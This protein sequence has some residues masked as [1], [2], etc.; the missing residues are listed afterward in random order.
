MLIFYFFILIRDKQLRVFD[1][2]KGKLRRKYDES[3]QVYQ[4]RVK[5]QN[6][7]EGNFLGK[8]NLWDGYREKYTDEKIERETDRQI[9]MK[10]I[11]KK[12]E[13]QRRREN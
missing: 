1:F 10:M 7:D 4:V 3:V 12:R 6:W 13:R 5:K 11:E 8:G 9:K 2:K